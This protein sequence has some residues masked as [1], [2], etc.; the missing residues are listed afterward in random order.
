MFLFAVVGAGE[1]PGS[2]VRIRA[3]AASR[4]V[5]RCHL[6]QAHSPGSRVRPAETVVLSRLL[7]QKLDDREVVDGR[8]RKLARNVTGGAIC[9]GTVIYRRPFADPS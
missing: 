4:R 5:R 1:K 8:E 9:P 2:R 6:L 3:P 7:P